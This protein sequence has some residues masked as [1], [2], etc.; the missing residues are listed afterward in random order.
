MILN[1][2]EESSGLCSRLLE[3]DIYASGMPGSMGVALF[4][5]SSQMWYNGISCGALRA[6]AGVRMG[7]LGHI[8]S[9]LAVE[10]LETGVSYMGN[11]P[12]LH[13]A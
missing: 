9:A 10:E 12:H 5:W 3:S 11:Q 8:A 1:L 6:S 13:D 2:P 4:A 7:E